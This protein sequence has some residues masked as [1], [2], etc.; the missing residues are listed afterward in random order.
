[1][2]KCHLLTQTS[3]AK[4][5]LDGKGSGSGSSLPSVKQRIATSLDPS[6][7]IGVEFDPKV[8][9]NYSSRVGL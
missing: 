8:E 4:H 3:S 6:W 2:N 9:T 1:M 5:V 7:Y